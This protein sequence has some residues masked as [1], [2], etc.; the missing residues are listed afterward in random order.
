[1]IFMANVTQRNVDLKDL[2]SCTVLS[3]CMF[4][5]QVQL[6]VCVVGITKTISINENSCLSFLFS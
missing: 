5:I 4:K 1:M 6:S 3:K 2:S